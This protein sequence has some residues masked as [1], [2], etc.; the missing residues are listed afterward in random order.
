M[1]MRS[2]LVRR[3]VFDQVVGAVVRL[4]AQLEGARREAIAAQEELAKTQLAEL[5]LTRE[6]AAELWQQFRGRLCQHCLGAHAR[7]CPRV[8]ELSFHPDAKLARVR[9]WRDGD[10]S[11]DG[12]LWPENLPPEPGESEAALCLR[13]SR[14]T[15]LP[16]CPARCLA[17]PCGSPRS[18][19]APRAS[20]F[21]G[22]RG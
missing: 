17:S 18:F 21:A 9:F 13:R 12:V 15:R 2:P 6:E 5:D 4:E 19:C 7:A 14:S 11:D 10:W 3:T 22:R 8:R 20:G 1:A 16:L